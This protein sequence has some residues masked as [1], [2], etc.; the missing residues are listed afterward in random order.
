MLFNTP[1][2]ACRKSDAIRV[3]HLSVPM[4]EAMPRREAHEDRT[5]E[6]EAI[7]LHAVPEGLFGELHSPPSHRDGSRKGKQGSAQTKSE[8]CLKLGNTYNSSQRSLLK[9]PW[10]K[11]KQNLNVML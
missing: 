10:F 7:L 2:R 3:R 11:L 4:P 8:H 6:V 9:A 5:R 1:D